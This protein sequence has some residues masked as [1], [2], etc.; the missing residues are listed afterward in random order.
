LSCV[1]AIEKAYQQIEQELQQT[2]DLVLTGG[3]ADK[4]A[5]HLSI[6]HDIIPELLLLGMQRYFGHSSLK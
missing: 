3:N 2:V 5:Q 6:S 1:A 4:I